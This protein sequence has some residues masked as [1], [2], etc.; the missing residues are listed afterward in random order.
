MLPRTNIFGNKNNKI[1]I[2]AAEFSDHNSFAQGSDVLENLLQRI[3]Y[4]A[5]NSFAKVNSNVKETDEHISKQRGKKRS[6][7]RSEQRS[8][9]RNHQPLV[10]QKLGRRRKGAEFK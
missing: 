1:A 6:E 7:Q 5:N 10:T 8:K 9:H 3:K 2:K 4:V